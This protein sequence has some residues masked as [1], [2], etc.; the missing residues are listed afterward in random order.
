MSLKTH[1][2]GRN[3]NR[4]GT[5]PRPLDRRGMQCPL[6]SLHPEILYRWGRKGVR[7]GRGGRRARIVCVSPRLRGR[8]DAHFNVLVN[9]LHYYALPAPL[10]PAPPSPSLPQSTISP[11]PPIPAA[12][13]SRH[14]VTPEYDELLITP[15]ENLDQEEEEM[16]EGDGR[17]EKPKN[18]GSIPQKLII[19]TSIAC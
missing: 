8:T 13:R 12:V 19:S 3:S 4:E 10:R 16:E 7:G 15:K 6:P 9:A 11:S 5:I 17:E 18:V 2:P 14:A 1:N